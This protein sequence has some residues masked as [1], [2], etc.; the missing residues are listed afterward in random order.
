MLNALT[1]VR[2]WGQSGHGPTAAYQSR[3]MSTRPNSTRSPSSRKTVAKKPILDA[4]LRS[5]LLIRDTRLTAAFDG[6]DSAEIF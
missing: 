1:N 4:W 5:D 3:F 6:F 2:F